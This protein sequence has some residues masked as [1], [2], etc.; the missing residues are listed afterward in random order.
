MEKAALIL[1]N[2][3]ARRASALFPSVKSKLRELGIECLEPREHEPRAFEDEIKKHRGRIDRVV[4]VGGDGTLGCVAAALLETGLPLG[5]IPSGTANNL[6]RNLGLPFETDEACVIAAGSTT[7]KIDLGIVNGIPFFNVVGI[8]MSS[9]I[10]RLVRHD[11]KKIFGGLAFAYT[12]LKH[13]NDFR[14]FQ[15]RITDLETGTVYLSKSLQIT[16]CNGRFFGTGLSAAAD[17]NID[18][19][20]LDLCSFE[21]KKP[22]DGFALIPNL[23]TGTFEKDDPVFLLRARRLRIETKRKFYVDVDGE[24]RTSTPLEVAVLPQSVSVF[25]PSTKATENTHQYS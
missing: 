21:I 20:A 22:G 16:V 19:A 12:A 5:V 1:H 2:P 13:M 11:L 3:H 14:Q 7:R 18:D 25:T 9:A 23:F 24:I 17:A 10:N 6:A 15:A 4:V 8:G